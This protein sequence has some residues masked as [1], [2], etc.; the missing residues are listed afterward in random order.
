MEGEGARGNNREGGRETRDL[1]ENESQ[2]FV[3]E[4]AGIIILKN[5]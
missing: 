4:S 1:R 2:W 3:L 5:S